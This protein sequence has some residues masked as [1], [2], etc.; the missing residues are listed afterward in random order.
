MRLRRVVVGLA[1]RNPTWTGNAGSMDRHTAQCAA[2]I[3]PYTGCC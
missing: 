2:L 1:Q 3:A